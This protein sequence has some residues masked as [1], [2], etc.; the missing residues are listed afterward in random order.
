[1]SLNFETNEIGP[2]IYITQPENREGLLTP[3]REYL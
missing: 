1:M 2:K 3:P